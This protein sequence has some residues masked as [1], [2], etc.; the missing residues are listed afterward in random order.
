MQ[1]PVL[2]LLILA[3]SLSAAPLEV[4]APFPATLILNRSGFTLGYAPDFKQSRWAAYVLTKTAL[5]KE[6]TARKDRFKADPSLPLDGPNLRDYR[7]S[8]YDRGHLAPAADMKWSTDAQEDCFYLSNMSPQTHRFNAGIWL[9]LENSVRDYTRRFDTLFI[10]TGPLLEYDLPTIG[11]GVA[12]PRSF[13]KALLTRSG[14]QPRAIAFLLPQ[15]AE[16]ADLASWVISVDSLEAITG[17]DFFPAL[18]DAVEDR[19]ESIENLDAWINPPPK[20]AEKPGI[21]AAREAPRRPVPMATRGY[22][23]DSRIFLV[24]GLALITC[25]LIV[26]ILMTISINRK[27]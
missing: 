7:G 26:F 8:G 18:P 19:A 11:S 24:W 17:L 12:V 2:L 5:E 21:I 22:F 25:A 16:G 10:A 15:T 23:A 27:P 3:A 13:W 4:P 20:A 1:S 6:V 14:G 9:R